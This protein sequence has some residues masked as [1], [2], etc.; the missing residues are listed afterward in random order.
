MGSFHEASL[1]SLRL[2]EKAFAW[3]PVLPQQL[4]AGIIHL[5]PSFARRSR[6]T[7]AGNSQ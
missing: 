1:I 2:F 3:Q 6:W 4:P 7:K 5:H